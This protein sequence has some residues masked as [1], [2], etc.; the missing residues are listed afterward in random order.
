MRRRG[1]ESYRKS[2]KRDELEGEFEGVL[3]RLEPSETLFGLVK[4]VFKDAWNMRLQQGAQAAKS[5]KESVRSLEKQIDQ[6]LDRMVEAANDSVV[7]AYEKRIARLG[8]EKVLALEKLSARA[9]RSIP[10][11]SRSNTPCDSS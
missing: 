9:S 8:G 1:C 10:L 3:Q 7:A 6:L 2:I 11:R 5:L 4:V